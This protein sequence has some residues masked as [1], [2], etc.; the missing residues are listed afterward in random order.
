MNRHIHGSCP[1]KS[2]HLGLAVGMVMVAGLLAGCQQTASTQVA[3]YD[4][5]YTRRHPILVS[6]EPS[7][8]DIPVGMRATK[9]SP[10]IQ[11][12][13]RSYVQDYRRTGT[14]SITIQVPSGSANEIAA[15]SVG[16]SAGHT[17]R[18]LGVPAGRIRVAPYQVDDAGKVAP[19]RLA[20]LKLKAHAPE[21]GI[22]P[23]DLGHTATDRSYYNFG[24]ANQQNLAAMIENPA[25]LVR[26]RDMTPA[27]GAQ[28][29]RVIDQYRA[30]QDSSSDLPVRETASNL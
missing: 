5:D 7:V 21:C 6:E 13:M 12:R 19:V 28:R 23:E 17:L 27:D 29:A 10:Q 8:L 26:P 18:K 11:R 20:F 2:R 22:W 30:G 9:L 1:A 25:D 3:L 16:R 4:Q 15:V 14:G 24:C